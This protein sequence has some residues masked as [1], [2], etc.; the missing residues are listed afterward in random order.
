MVWAKLPGFPWWPAIIISKLESKN[1]EVLYFGDF[2]RSYLNALSLRKFQNYSSE[3]RVSGSLAES[4]KIAEQFLE[5]K[6]SFEEIVSMV[7][8][9]L[10]KSNVQRITRILKKPNSISAFDNME[11]IGYKKSSEDLKSETHLK[12]TQDSLGSDL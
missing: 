3:E 11:S 9:K 10:R 7:D 8:R 4:L 5:Q 12:N 2:T 1:Y 6:I